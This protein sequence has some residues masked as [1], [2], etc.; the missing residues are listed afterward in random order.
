[1][2]GR[3]EPLINPEFDSI[4][5]PTDETLETIE[6][7]QPEFDGDGFPWAGL[8]SFCREAWDVK[9]GAI[10]DEV[11]E[12]GEKLLCFVTGGWSANEMVTGAM[13]RNLM[14]RA[15]CWHSAYRG[16][17]VKYVVR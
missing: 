3:R 6:Q 8:I 14:F 4:G 17:L 5:D 12:E 11:N 9:Y 7:W 16:G 13:E 2:P 15:M 10:R 1:M